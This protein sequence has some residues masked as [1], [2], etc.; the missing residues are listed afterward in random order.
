MRLA[1]ALG[2][3]LFVTGC[4]SGQQ[5]N[6]EYG[7]IAGRHGTDSLNGV[8]VLADM[9]VQ[10]GF[11]VKRR[12]KISPR[13]EKFETIV[14]FPDDYS[15]PSEEA[16]ESLNQWLQNANG[17]TKRTL[18][19]V[20]RDYDAR[21]DY[22]NRVKDSAP[23]QQREEL[24]RRIAEARLAQDSQSSQGELFWFDADI[25]TC[26]W[27]EQE[28]L[29]RQ[30]A[31][32]LTGPM[33]DQVNARECVVEYST[34]LV[35]TQ[36]TLDGGGR[37]EAESLLKADGHPTVLRLT[38]PDIAPGESEI[39]VIS[40]GSFLL[41]YTLI[42]SEHRK[43]AGQ[44]IDRCEPY[45]DV[46]FLES[47][48]RGIDVSDSDT[49]NHN[50]WAWI[51]QPPL[52]YIVPH[53]LMWG[54]LFCFVYFPIFGRPRRLKKGNTTTFRSHINAMGKLMGRSR[55]PNGAINRIRNYQHL[56]SGESKRTKPDE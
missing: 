23:I 29:G 18:I 49:I 54:I 22:L 36:E 56:I 46:L 39:L 3:L 28:S 19:Y 20:G 40:N 55:L 15:C 25:S 41:N 51:A 9:F 11:K 50:T 42:N 17:Y 1:S 47:G 35:A 45:E 24:L 2:L 7:K 14:W 10:R 32:F 33:S 43:L 8:S 44:L 12:T 48:R 34:I 21:T 5:L 26:E 52:R 53:F 4:G 38:R 30:K 37:W 16:I 27:F 6:T 13:I 31:Q